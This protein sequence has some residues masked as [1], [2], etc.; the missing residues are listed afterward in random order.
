[1]VVDGLA[2][3][4]GSRGWGEEVMLLYI[5]TTFEYHEPNQLMQYHSHNNYQAFSLQFAY[6]RSFH[7]VAHIYISN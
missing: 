5:H 4:A 3:K 2:F 7:S 6:M 1:M